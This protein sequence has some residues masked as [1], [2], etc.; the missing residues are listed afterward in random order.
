VVAKL[1]FQ[2]TFLDQPFEPS[3]YIPVRRLLR[4]ELYPDITEAPELQKMFT[5]AGSSHAI[6]RSREN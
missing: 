1:P 6:I 5:G 2:A 4:N 3:L